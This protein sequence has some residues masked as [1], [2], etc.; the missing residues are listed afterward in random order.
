MYIS[1]VALCVCSSGQV[2]LD[3]PEPTGCAAVP[4]VERLRQG[5]SACVSRPEGG[6]DNGDHGAEAK[7][8]FQPFSDV[9]AV[10]TVFQPFLTNRFSAVSHV[11]LLCLPACLGKSLF[12]VETQAKCVRFCAEAEPV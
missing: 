12:D 1:D 2:R 6:R 5:P 7:T 9:S 3:L 10:S 8:V 11:V 4:H